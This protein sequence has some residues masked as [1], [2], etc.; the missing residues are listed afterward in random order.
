MHHQ[1][2]SLEERVKRHLRIP[3]K[4]KLLWLARMLELNSSNKLKLRKQ[5]RLMARY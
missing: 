3:I 2:E 5:L 4:N 1:W